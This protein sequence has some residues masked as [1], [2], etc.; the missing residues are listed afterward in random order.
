MAGLSVLFKQ[1][2]VFIQPLLA[3]EQRGDV[4]ALRARFPY[5]ADIKVQDN[6][7]YN[8]NFCKNQLEGQFDSESFGSL[9]K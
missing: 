6:W 1:K 2:H 3:T 4:Q 7:T 5:V 9:F 8:N